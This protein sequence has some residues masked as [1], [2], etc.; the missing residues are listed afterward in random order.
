MSRKVT[1][2]VKLKRAYDP[3][4][5]SD[6]RRVLVDRLWPRGISKDELR[7][8]DWLKDVAP[9]SM[10]RKWF[11]HDP[12]KWCEFKNRYF[13]ELDERSEAI[14]YL[15]ARG[16]EGTVTLVFGAKDVHHNDAVALKEYL[17]RRAK[18][19]ESVRITARPEVQTPPWSVR[20]HD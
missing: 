15:L 3:P 5:R 16:R 10:L 1:Q 12:A 17:E 4:A 18:Q 13:R 6:G 9:S 7:L 2:K 8:D 11:G 14:E 19:Y 20:G